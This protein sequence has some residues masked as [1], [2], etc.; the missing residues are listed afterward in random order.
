MDGLRGEGDFGEK[1]DDGF[2]CFEGGLG[3]LEVDFG[4]SGS[5]DAVEE[6]GFWRG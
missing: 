4:F 1:D 3:G 2:S 5:G 6:D